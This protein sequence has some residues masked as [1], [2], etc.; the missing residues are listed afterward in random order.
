[1]HDPGMQVRARAANDDAAAGTAVGT[2][3]MHASAGVVLALSAERK[4]RRTA[5]NQERQR[6]PRQDNDNLCYDDLLGMVRAE[7][8]Q[9]SGM[10]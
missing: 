5:R 10:P 1:M 9:P 6:D 3:G 2:S 8:A 4:L 7:M